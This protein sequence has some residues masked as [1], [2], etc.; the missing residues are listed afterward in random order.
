MSGSSI[1]P[2]TTFLNCRPANAQ[3]RQTAPICGATRNLLHDPHTH[4]THTRAREPLVQPARAT[5]RES[6][7]YAR[8]RRRVLGRQLPTPSDTYARVLCGRANSTRARGGGFWVGNFRHL[9]THTRA[10]VKLVRR[11]SHPAGNPVAWST[12]GATNVDKLE[13]EDTP[14]VRTE[15]Q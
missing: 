15:T 1:S 11:Y 12:D 8:A 4:R 5:M 14:A 9:P 7:Q 3:P 2:P 10:G 13:R 6:E